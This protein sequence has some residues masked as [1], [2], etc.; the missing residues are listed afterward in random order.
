M[1]T[2]IYK[3][4]QLIQFF[5]FCCSIKVAVLIGLSH[6]FF[7]AEHFKSPS[8]TTQ[9]AC[10]LLLFFFDQIQTTQ[11][12]SYLHQ[13]EQLL[14]LPSLYEKKIASFWWRFSSTT[15]SLDPVAD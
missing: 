12:H 15:P 13:Q 8:W 1:W 14:L 4:G 3:I 11:E 5:K 7:S 2:V 9:H 6:N 10:L